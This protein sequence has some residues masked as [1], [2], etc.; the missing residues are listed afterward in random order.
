[1]EDLDRRIAAVR[2]FNRI[3]TQR[4]GVLDE[5]YLDTSF[6]LAESRVLYELSRH[7]GVTA[8][9]IAA[10][11]ALDP[12]YLS[13]ILRGFHR[14]GLIERRRA[15]TDRRQSMLSLT[16]A[17]RAAFAPL[18]NGARQA[19]AG[20]LAPMSPPGQARLVA[21]MR[22]IATLLGAE[23]PR[24]QA[25]LLRP[26][27]P[28]DLGWIVSRHGALYAEEYGWDARFEAMVA[29]TAAA[30]LRGFDERRDACW[31]AEQDGR[32]V[33]SVALV[34]HTATESRLRVLL[35]EPEARGLGIGARLV[36]ECLR[37]ARRVGYTRIML[38]TYSVLT[39][40]RR[41]YAAAGF[42]C[43]EQH[44]ESNFGHDLVGETWELALQPGAGLT[45]AGAAGSATPPGRPARPSR[46]K[47]CAMRQR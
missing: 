28:G 21:A 36:E 47:S 12:G 6:S 31:I 32:N 37:F 1:M 30:I 14:R 34:G 24:S 2:R 20:L 10:G 29:E 13:R 5:S 26:H 22:E 27:R 39:A 18:D 11:L 41:I 15:A 3:Y 17:G 8:T 46:P 23:P 19:I 7:G 25:Y 9:A 45:T 43:V 38:T 35:V 40:A 4:I 16:E 42:R 44:P 33:G